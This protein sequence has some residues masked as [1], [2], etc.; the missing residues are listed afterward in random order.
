ME[1]RQIMQLYRE[2][3][4]HLFNVTFKPLIDGVDESAFDGF[5]AAW[6]VIDQYDTVNA[7]LFSTLVLQTLKIQGALGW[8]TQSRITRRPGVSECADSH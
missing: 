4:R 3:S 6:D 7:C 2:S 8:A 1:I 5:H